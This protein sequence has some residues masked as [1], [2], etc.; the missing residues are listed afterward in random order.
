MV[1]KGKA[2]DVIYLDLCKASDMVPTTS[3]SLN[4]RDVDLKGGLFGGLGI[5]WKVVDR[6]LW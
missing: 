2:M 5:G 6:G 4:W 1:D 3:L